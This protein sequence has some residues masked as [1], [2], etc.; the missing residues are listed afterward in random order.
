MTFEMVKDQCTPQKPEKRDCYDRKQI[1]HPTYGCKSDNK[2]CQQCYHWSYEPEDQEIVEKVC[3]PCEMAKVEK[4]TCGF[5]TVCQC[6]QFDNCF[7]DPPEELACHKIEKVLSQDTFQCDEESEN[8]CKAC[9]TWKYVSTELSRNTTECDNR[10]T[11]KRPVSSECGS[12]EICQCNGKEKS[13]CQPEK[14][15]E[16]AG[17]CYSPVKVLTQD[18]FMCDSAESQKCVQCWTWTYEKKPCLVQPPL[19]CSACETE[20]IVHTGCGCSEKHCVPIV[21]DN[22]QPPKLEPDQCYHEAEKVWTEVSYTPNG[23]IDCYYWN[24]T[25]KQQPQSQEC[26]LKNLPNECYVSHHA[27]GTCDQIVEKCTENVLACEETY[28]DG[29]RECAVG[30]KMV[31]LKSKCGKFRDAC[32]ECDKLVSSLPILNHPEECYSDHELSILGSCTQVIKLK[33]PCDFLDNIVPKI[34]E[35]GM[36]NKLFFD[37]CNCPKLKC[38]GCPSV[39]KVD[40]QL[41]LDSS[42]SMGTHWRGLI[43]K[44]KTDFIGSVMS[45]KDSKMG[46]ARFGETLVEITPLSSETSGKTLD[47]HTDFTNMGRT[48]TAGALRELLP[49]FQKAINASGESQAEKVLVVITDGDANG[50]GNVSEEAKKW[51]AAVDAIHVLGFGNL[52]VEGLKEINGGAPGVVLLKP[53][54]QALEKAILEQIVPS[55]CGQEKLDI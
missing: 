16:E 10:C 52:D 35:G 45:N 3:K 40:V 48:H 44:I 26:T 27:T 12:G 51:V 7:P 17:D 24:R 53:N 28:G 30:H 15:K 49:S 22:C 38:F 9:Y 18:S 2:T 39:K 5:R 23:C 6:R 46:I 37:D 33:K 19:T 42:G 32:A 13:Y 43:N 41:L 29:R 14:P 20:K 34:C 54:L 8:G 55:I 50:P 4:T 31:T 11:Y 25:R 21:L 1:H 36:E 47:S